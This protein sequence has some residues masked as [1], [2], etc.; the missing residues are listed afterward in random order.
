[1]RT[2]VSLSAGAR[3]VRDRRMAANCAW[4]RAWLQP[5]QADEGS[6]VADAIWRERLAIRDRMLIHQSGDLPPS[7]EMSRA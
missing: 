2:P 7:E 3:N 5:W 6:T 4:L 1:M